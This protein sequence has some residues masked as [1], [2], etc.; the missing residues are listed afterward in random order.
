MQIQ[1]SDPSHRQHTQNIASAQKPMKTQYLWLKQLC[2]VA[3]VLYLG[4]Y[5]TV[6]TR[7][8]AASHKTEQI[9]RRPLQ[10]AQATVTPTVDDTDADASVFRMQDAAGNVM[11]VPNAVARPSRTSR[12]SSSRAT[13]T[14][15]PLP[16][17]NTPQPTVRATVAASDEGTVGGLQ[18]LVT[19]LL[20]N[21]KLQPWIVGEKRVEALP[22]TATATVTAAATATA[23]PTATPAIAQLQQGT[24]LSVAERVTALPGTS[25]EFAAL[26]LTEQ[27]QPLAQQEVLLFIDGSPI[28]Q[29]ETDAWGV[30]HFRIT[31]ALTDGDHALKLLF[32]GKD[33][34]Q[35]A[36]AESVLHY[37]VA[38]P[39]A[40]ERDV[41]NSSETTSGTSVAPALVMKIPTS[42]QQSSLVAVSL[43]A[44]RASDHPWLALLA[45]GMMVGLVA[46]PTI[47]RRNNRPLSA[48]RP[49][50]LPFWQAG[51]WQIP[52]PLWYALRM[53]SVGSA[54]GI[55][56]VLFIRP[57]TGLFV[58]WRLIIPCLPLLFFLAPALWRN[59]CPMAALNQTR[60]SSTLAKAGPCPSGCNATAIWSRSRSF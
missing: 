16:A 4:Y 20:N 52:L 13:A 11:L 23:A 38:Q 34:L 54:I 6:A 46:S 31:Q 39:G 8:Q 17:S 56:I 37:H 47:L 2:L 48:N 5:S 12:R 7:L 28:Q 60:A 1:K 26:L 9:A 42:I 36:L 41:A 50:R 30:V 19:M 3:T 55:A 22:P 49:L 57:Q 40:G 43:L 25:V 10:Q 21:G 15:T 35:P 27:Q 59:I 14:V 24:L 33:Y 45:L 32:A 58:F 29:G 44:N 51:S 18:S 53:G